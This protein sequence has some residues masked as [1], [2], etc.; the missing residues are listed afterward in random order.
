MKR[1]IRLPYSEVQRKLYEKYNGNIIMITDEKN[2]L[3]SHYNSEFKCMICNNTWKIPYNSIISNKYGC[4]SCYGR[5]KKK[6][7]KIEN[8]K[9]ELFEKF[10][11]KILSDEN[12]LLKS[13][14]Y[15]FICNKCN[16]TW[17]ANLANILNG[18]KCCL[19][20]SGHYHYDLEEIKDILN[21]NNENI[22]IIDNSYISI[23]K[24][25]KFKCKKCN[26]EWSIKTHNVITGFT[27]CPNCKK[28]KG[29]RI[30]KNFLRDK[31]INHIEQ[32]TFDHCK[33]KRKLPFDFYLPEHNTCIEFDG[34]QH[35]SPWKDNPKYL[36]EFFKIKINDNIKNNYC[37]TNN[38]KLI[39]IPYT[40]INNID[41]VLKKELNL[42]YI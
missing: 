9:K 30:I 23:S 12:F 10:N 1:S 20:C 17:E 6:P 14:K 21:K 39:R 32:Y 16:F 33:N 18:K 38:I 41:V 25:S 8:V 19:K 42:C 22:V 26:H 40:E 3:G 11:I 13:R 37:L 2:Y 15:N 34:Y 29:E 7:L 5:I 27:G 28:S 31:N 36:N 24:S 35:F 4:P